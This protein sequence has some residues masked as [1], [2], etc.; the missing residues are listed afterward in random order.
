MSR[1]RGLSKFEDSR[2]AL[3]L[4]TSELDHVFDT[5]S[6]LQLLCHTLL[7]YAGSELRQ[8]TSFSSWLRQE[9]ETQATDPLS[10]AAEENLDKDVMPDYHQ[11]LEYVQGAMQ[12][13]Q[14]FELLNIPQPGQSHTGLETREDNSLLYDQYKAEIK[15]IRQ[16]KRPEKP[17][18][19]LDFLTDRLNRQCTAI[20]QRTAAAQGRKVR[21]GNHIDICEDFDCCDMRMMPKVSSPRIPLIKTKFQ[22]GC[23]GRQRHDVRICRYSLQSTSICIE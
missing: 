11:I 1:L 5:I 13:S 12:V 7:I 2:A 19:G 23:I 14:L 4:E 6:C 16:G 17:L 15:K 20:F 3:D 8:F 21:F 18:P 9:I 22:V 10:T